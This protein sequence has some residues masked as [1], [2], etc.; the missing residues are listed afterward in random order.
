MSAWLWIAIILTAPF[1]MILLIVIGAYLYALMTF[2]IIIIAAVFEEF[3]K[4]FR[5]KR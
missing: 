4:L 1:W 3:F 5:R 2:L